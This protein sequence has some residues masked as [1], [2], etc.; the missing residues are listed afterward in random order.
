M[1]I[2][3]SV[4]FTL[5]SV[6]CTVGLLARPANA[7]TPEPAQA[8][9]S[10][11]T[12]LLAAGVGSSSGTA[13]VWTPMSREI[14]LRIST[15]AISVT[16]KGVQAKI[17]PSSTVFDTRQ[18]A[19]WDGSKYQN[20]IRVNTIGPVTYTDRASTLRGVCVSYRSTIKDFLEKR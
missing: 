12:Q 1:R 16:S 20:S 17:L 9:Q 13:Q 2:R 3:S 5:M 10:C 4:V 19:V 7:Q 14:H 11:Q 6:A 8:D 18:S 15:P